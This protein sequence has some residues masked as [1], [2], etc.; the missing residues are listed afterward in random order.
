MK[1]YTAIGLAVL[2]AVPS[3]S[4]VALADGVTTEDETVVTDAL[5]ME[6]VKRLPNKCPLLNI[7]II[8]GCNHKRY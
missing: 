8:R 7:V 2:L 1:K 5:L 3:I 6:Q 4:S